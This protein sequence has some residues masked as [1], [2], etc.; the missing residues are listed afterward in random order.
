MERPRHAEVLVE[1]TSIGHATQTG[2]EAMDRSQVV[3]LRLL[4]MHSRECQSPGS[5]ATDAASK[6]TERVHVPGP[7][8]GD[9]YANSDKLG[10]QDPGT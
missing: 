6:S 7:T 4:Y 8:T 10:F 5:R 3:P 9:P 1:P 2:E